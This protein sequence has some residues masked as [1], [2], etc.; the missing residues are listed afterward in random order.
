MVEVSKLEHLAVVTTCNACPFD[1]TLSYINLFNFFKAGMV[2]EKSF[3]TTKDR[4]LYIEHCANSRAV[5]I[6][7]R[8]GKA[9]LF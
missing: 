8:G 4:M 2:R 3:G 9:I 7:I 6:F 5:T 1:N